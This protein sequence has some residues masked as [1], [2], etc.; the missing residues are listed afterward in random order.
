MFNFVRNNT[1]I[2]MVVLFLLVIPSFALVGLDG[3]TSFN[4]RGNK[5]ARVDGKD[6]TQT[7]W[8]NVHR[9]EIERVRASNPNVDV[10]QLDTPAMKYATLERMVRDR[11]L[12]AAA[13]AEHL[14]ATDQRLATELQNDA[15]IASL[16]KPD[17]TLDMEMYRQLLARQ[18]LTPEGFEANVRAE[19]SARQVL[20]TVMTSGVASQAQSDVALGAFLEQREVQVARFSPAD[21]A[22]KINPTEADLEGFYKAHADRYQAPEAASVE[23]IVLDLASVKKAVALSE[24][25][26]KTYYDQNAASFGTKEERR[27]SHILVIASR[28]A[29][30][31]DRE[32][33]KAKAQELLAEVRKTPGSFAA[34]AKRASQDDMSAPSGG[35]LG[36]FQSDKGLDPAINKAAF[37]LAKKGD[38]SDVVESEFGYH[39]VELT[40]I[41]PAV[42]PT[43]QE[44]RAKLEDQLRTEQA[45]RQFSE[46]ADTFTNG[47][48]EQADSLKP[49]AE[50]LK[51]P[52]QTAS[53]IARTPAPG[54]SG[55]L[56]SPKFLSALFSS[57]SLSKKR[58]TEAIEVGPNQLAAGRVTQYTA[59]HARPFAEVKSEVQA[60][61]ISVRG[62]EMARKEGEARLAAWR[63]QPASATTL[64]APIVISRENPQEQP[65]VLLEAVLRADATKPPVFVG[66]DLGQAGYAVARVNKIVPRAVS[67]ADAAAQER[68]RYEQLWG[69]AEAKA[70]YDLL[71]TRFKGEILVP[72]VTAGIPGAARAPQ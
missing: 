70:Y 30:A 51:L 72:A 15:S 55:P 68:L 56:A 62:A 28:D 19:L 67:A 36:F 66:V 5:V 59:A 25:D 4:E 24:Q 27:A 17:G 50:K 23:Y 21:F 61:Y 60:R 42:I 12:A 26:L 7:E 44:L 1:K 22:S 46:L 37:G 43:F 65:A 69:S 18:G 9:Q 35:D 13:N 40:D 32:K 6:I 20:G 63:A 52:I 64:P 33:A 41:K 2:M 57:E 14:S 54:A 71:K 39:I 11:V 3:Y 47:V 49:I 45:Q 31:A 8:D 53:N 38:V 48:F 29:S 58:N 10:A 34:V 16:R